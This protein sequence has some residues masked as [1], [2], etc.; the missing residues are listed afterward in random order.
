MFARISRPHYTSDDP[1]YT[2]TFAEEAAA[3]EALTLDEVKQF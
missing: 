2:R 1:R 3:L